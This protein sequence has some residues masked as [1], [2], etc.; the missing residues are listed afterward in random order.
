MNMRM[1][2]KFT[3]V[4][5]VSYAAVGAVLFTPGIPFLADHFGVSVGLIQ[6]TVILYLFA[7]AF[8]LLFWGPI[9][10]KLGRK[11]SLVVGALLSIGGCF[12]SAISS[13]VGSLSMLLIGRFITSFGSGSGFVLT[14]VII[15]DLL[16]KKQAREMVSLAIKSF[17]IFPC[18]AVIVGGFLVRYIGWESTFYFQACYI[19]FIL[20]LLFGLQDTIE[21]KDP[22]ALKNLFSRY[23]PFFRNKK[24]VAYAAMVGMGTSIFYAFAG[25]GPVLGISYLGIAP[26][27]YGLLAFIPFFGLFISTIISRRLSHLPS[28]KVIPVA[29]FV[30]AVSIGVFILGFYFFRNVYTLFFPMFFVYLAFGVIYPF[31]SIKSSGAI[32]GESERASSAMGFINVL[33]SAIF[34][35]IISFFGSY[36]FFGISFVFSLAVVLDVL[37]YLWGR[38]SSSV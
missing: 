33:V 8:G 15:H 18:L 3:L 25:I 13:N 4:L 22:K 27:F 10:R 30:E 24:V 28:N 1:L 34:M 26:D 14:F 36:A 20:L 2:L 5:L 31:A 23:K 11:Q 32:P 12:L 35:L 21:E 29:L 9:A 6:W 19:G 7:Y 17:A 37:M 16:E 38:S